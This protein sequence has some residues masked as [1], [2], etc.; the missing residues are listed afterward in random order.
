MTGQT[1]ML[2]D[3]KQFTYWVAIRLAWALLII[4]LIGKSPAARDDSDP[5]TWGPRSGLVPRTDSLTGCQYLES[6]R[7]ALTPRLNRDGQH[8]CSR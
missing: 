4:V 5:G 2:E 7:G 8:I 3:L 6:S 1:P